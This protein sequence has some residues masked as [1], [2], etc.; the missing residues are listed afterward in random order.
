LI[1]KSNE[2]EI[3]QSKA[4]YQILMKLGNVWAS[5]CRNEQDT[6][7]RKK[8]L[9]LT[10]TINKTTKDNQQ[11]SLTNTI[12]KTTKGNLNQVYVKGFWNNKST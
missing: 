12:N 11:L 1:N 5:A 7:M 2:E 10:N 9:S 3:E 8:K 6:T 4:Q